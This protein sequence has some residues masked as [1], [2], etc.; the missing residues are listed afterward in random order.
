MYKVLKFF[1]DMQDDNYPYEAGATYP[2]KGVK[3]D[4][5][6][7]AELASANNKRGCPLIAE[8]KKKDEE[9]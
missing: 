1:T 5:D 3:P 4:K 2:R 7:I 8:V 6:R 9:E